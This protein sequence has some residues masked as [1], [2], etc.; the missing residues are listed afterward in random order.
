MSAYL[1]VQALAERAGHPHRKV[2]LGV[3]VWGRWSPI[4][5]AIRAL[6]NGLCFG[7]PLCCVE[8]FALDQ[9]AGR[10]PALRRGWLPTETGGRYVPCSGCCREIG[11]ET[12][13]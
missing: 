6:A 7:Y 1:T 4:E 12:L 9:L 13:L 10:C 3:E 5:A 8:E 2:D 11:R